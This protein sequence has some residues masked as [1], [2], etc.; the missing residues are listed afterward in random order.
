[1]SRRRLY[2]T[3]VVVSAVGDHHV[4][5]VLNSEHNISI[6][7]WPLSFLSVM[8]IYIYIPFMFADHYKKLT[9]MM[10]DVQNKGVHFFYCTMGGMQEESHE[11]LEFT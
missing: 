4:L 5:T 9:K 7:F 11:I 6:N 3:L 1:M 2:G 8:I 10:W